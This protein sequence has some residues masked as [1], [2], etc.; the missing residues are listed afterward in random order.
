MPPPPPPP[1][2]PPNFTN[3]KQ[4]GTSKT[5]ANSEGTSRKPSTTSS[6]DGTKVKTFL[7][8]LKLFCVTT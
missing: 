3:T 5:F 4:E 6:G 2:P 8:F 1:P 7:I